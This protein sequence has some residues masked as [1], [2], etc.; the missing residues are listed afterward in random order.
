M[1]EII[2]SGAA[3]I[4]LPADRAV[5][6]VS[7]AANGPQREEVM[8]QAA[9][10]HAR[11]VA[12]AV[13][14][15][16]AGSAAHYVASPIDTYTNSWRDERGAQT[17]EHHAG[18]SVSIELSELGLVAELTFELAQS[19]ADARVSWELSDAQRRDAMRALRAEAVA[20][21][22]RTA[23]DYAVAL[24]DTVGVR[25][26]SLRDGQGGYGGPIPIMRA[27]MA[28]D[29]A[30]PEVTAREVEVSV[31]LEATFVTV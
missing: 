3:Q 26:E 6:N 10:E 7:V 15:V 2:V 18:V 30:A 5:V 4:R 29:K 28:A 20:D 23:E 31:T 27:A 8:R 12:R 16:D 9:A 14:L 19:G 22:R 21:A 13:Q 25:L 11:L 17:T 1:T 24:G